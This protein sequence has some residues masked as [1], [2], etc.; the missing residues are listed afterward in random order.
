MLL[1]IVI[2]VITRGL[3]SKFIVEG[4]KYLLWCILADGEML[5]LTWTPRIFA[6]ILLGLI[7][8]VPLRVE[9]RKYV[10]KRLREGSEG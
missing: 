9:H 3:V 4:G 6:M 1:P 2:E 7:D 8:P 10:P 5:A